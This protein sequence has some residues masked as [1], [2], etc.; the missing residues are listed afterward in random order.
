MELDVYVRDANLVRVGELD[1]WTR[2]EVVL[3]HVD[4]GEATIV[5]PSEQ[6]DLIDF[7]T[8]LQIMRDG[9]PLFTGTLE[10]VVRTS[11]VEQDLIACTYVDDMAYLGA[12]LALPDPL[13]AV[14]GQARDAFTGPAESALRYFVGRNAG[15]A[16]LGYRQIGLTFPEGDEGRGLQLQLG[17]RFDNLLLLCRRI[18]ILGGL[19]F[20]VTDTGNAL[21]FTVGV[22][23]DRTQSA[24]FSYDLGTL[25]DYTYSRAAATATAP[26]VASSGEGSNRTYAVPADLGGVGRARREAFVDASDT[27]TADEL[28]QSVEEA[29]ADGAAKALLEA[30]PVDSESV[31]YGR[32]YDLGDRVA[33][34][35]DGIDASDVVREV[36][37]TYTS[38]VGE[39]V[40]P[41]I[42]TVTL[43]DSGFLGRLRRLG[44]RLNQ[45]E[46]R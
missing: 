27:L 29:I 41:V 18:A 39:R 36:R 5:L 23:G 13:D 25:T 15:P 7:G 28:L 37:L 22:P 38:E 46:R 19:S 12:R 16:A 14:P 44:S 2:L 24:Q 20:R 11:T 10:R 4:I 17:A 43:T 35:V 21:A 3:R 40:T 42:G 33:V 8:G 30:S 1:L 34:T 6:A 45:L 32:D 26:Y 9:D 31:R